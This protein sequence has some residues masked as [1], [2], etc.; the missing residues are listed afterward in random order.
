MFRTIQPLEANRMI[1]PHF[2]THKIGEDG[3]AE[4]VDVPAQAEF[5]PMENFELDKLLK[6]GVPLQEVNT[7]VLG[8]RE[9]YVDVD[10]VAGVGS[11]STSKTEI[12]TESKTEA[13]EA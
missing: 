5:P 6:A 9:T 1:E 11:K 10:K 2:Q 4:L 8:I 13:K 3:V 12:K 7:K